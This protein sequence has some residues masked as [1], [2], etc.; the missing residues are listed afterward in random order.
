V[1]GHD[2]RVVAVSQ[3]RQLDPRRHLD[4]SQ[5]QRVVQVHARE[6][7]FEELR[8]IVRQAGDLGVRHH[9][10]DHAAL[11]LDA[12]G[13]RL[14]LEVDGQVQA[15]LFA[16]DHAL[17]IQMHDGVAGRVHLHVADNR[18][19]FFSA[20]DD[21]DDRR[22]KPLIPDQSENLAMIQSERSWLTLGAIENRGT[23]P[24]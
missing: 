8:Q 16:L 11:G 1:H 4:V 9:V 23:L 20:D 5:E 14:A 17:Q 7:E 2:R 19:L 22:E 12:R 6:V 10:R 3:A 18:R 13:R 15:D 24:A 21:A